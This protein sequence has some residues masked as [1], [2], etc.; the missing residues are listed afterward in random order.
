LFFVVSGASIFFLFGLGY[1]AANALCLKN[2]HAPFAE[3]FPLIMIAGFLVN[4]LILLLSQSLK[5]SL[6]L[7]VM[8]GGCGLA[9][10]L[11]RW[12]KEMISDRRGDWIP[13]AAIALILLLHYLTVLYAPLDAWDWDARSIWFFHAKMIWSAESINLNAGWNH[14]SVQFS[15]VDYPMLVPALAA[16]FS[17]A[18]GYWNEYAP[19]F[20]LFLLFLPAIFWIFSFYSRRLSFLF[21]VLVFPFGFKILLWN[22]YLDGYIALYAAISMLLLGRYFQEQRFLDLMSAVSCLALLSN[23]KNEGILLGLIGAAAIAVTG[24]LSTTFKW[25]EFKKHLNIYRMGWLIVMMAPCILWSVF[26]RYQWRLVNDLQIGT[27]DALFRMSSRFLD[28]V[29]FPLILKETMFHQENFFRPLS[30]SVW[31]AFA[32]FFA[33]IILLTIFKR[34]IV[35]WIPALMMAVAYYGC[36]LAIYLMTPHDLIWHLGTSVHR[37]ML[38]VSSC[39]FAGTFF[40]LKE[41]EDATV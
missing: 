29:S 15:H 3:K 13:M 37:T 41:I 25:N 40:V 18:L 34:Y 2:D 20:S 14:P 17:Y 4:H 11:M 27:A 39:I 19:K 12:K 36:V 31:L 21:L 38:T 35:G 32:L 8:I 22:G 7:G 10:F 30:S 23:M 16:Q 5:L 6:L 26:Y 1:L 33:G 9:W 24:M 28:G